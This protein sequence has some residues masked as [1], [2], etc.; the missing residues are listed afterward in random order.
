VPAGTARIRT[1][2]LATHTAEDLAL[3]LSAVE[4]VAARL[5]LL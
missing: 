4:R 2:I 1:S 5:R 3:A